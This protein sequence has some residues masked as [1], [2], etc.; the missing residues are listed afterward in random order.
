MNSATAGIRTT[1]AL[2]N[3]RESS[4]RVDA[5]RAAYEAQLRE[6]V[7]ERDELIQDARAAGIPYARI[8]RETKLSRERIRQIVNR[9]E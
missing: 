6:A 7:T 9:G 8:Q 5:L 2:A 4:E 1:L 3:L